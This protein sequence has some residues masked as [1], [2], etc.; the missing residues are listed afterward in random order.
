VVLY[1]SKRTNNFSRVAKG[2]V[3]AE[4][5]TKALPDERTS[6]RSSLEALLFY[7]GIPAITLYPLGFVALSIQIWRD[8]VF[9][10][11][12]ATGGFNFAM[13]WYAASL[14]PEMLV[15]GTG[16]RLLFLALLPTVFSVGIASTA[17]YFLRRHVTKSRAER[18]GR[19][20]FGKE[21]TLSKRE[22][23]FW[24]LSLLSLLPLVILVRQH[25][26][27]IDSWYDV[28]FL[29]GYAIFSVAGGA[30]V[31]YMR[32]WGHRERWL[33]YGLALAFTGAILAALSLSALR[34]PDLPFVQFRATSEWPNRLP[35]P[36]FR[37]LSSN[38]NIVYV[39][40]RQSGIL[41]VNQTVGPTATQNV[42]YWDTPKMRAPDIDPGKA[43]RVN[44][45]QDAR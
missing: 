28:P 23:R 10:Y 30:T 9:P 32:F 20:V 22:R 38:K 5:N 2:E 29:A 31:G 15:V 35:S 26:F 33:R 11:S 41:A 36:Y 18:E 39:Y 16:V 3:L 42:R 21:A 19:E 44:S 34:L 14:V 40:N 37:L 4:S 17:L 24:W 7:I 1:S 45:S 25:N 12:W 6:F 8:P 43:G 27:P 13:I